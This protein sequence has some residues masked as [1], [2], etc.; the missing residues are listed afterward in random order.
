M[1]KNN[2]DIIGEL[3]NMGTNHARVEE[4]ILNLNDMVSENIEATEELGKKNDKYMREK[5]NI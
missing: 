3:A 1:Q 2:S 5:T 4:E